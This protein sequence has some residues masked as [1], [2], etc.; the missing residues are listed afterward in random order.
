[1]TVLEK[2][3]K[4][5]Q[6][7]AYIQNLKLEEVPWH[8]IT[9]AYGLATDLQDELKTVE[10][11]ANRNKVKEALSEIE[12]FIEHQSTLWHSTPFAMIFL[13]R[14]FDKAVAEMESNQCARYVV[15]ELL[16]FFSLIAE[17]YHDYYEEYEEEE[18][19]ETFP[20]FSDMLKEEFLAPEDCDED[21]EEEL[22]ETYDESPEFFSCCYYY[23][24]QVLLTCKP[25]LEKLEHVSGLDKEILEKVK[26]LQEQL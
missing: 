22:Y 9:T 12:N 25:I 18:D 13:V 23:S 5:D 7:Q 16:D 15:E 20:L 21:A 6:N 1:M 3:R 8:R 14:A 26:E 17:C 11:M 24:F 10:E 19:W 4:M 2:E